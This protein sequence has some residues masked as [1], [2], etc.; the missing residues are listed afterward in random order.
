MDMK[1]NLQFLENNIQLKYAW[2]VDIWETI[3][4]NSQSI[5]LQKK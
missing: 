3:Y 1:Y 2:D 4:Y 5:Y